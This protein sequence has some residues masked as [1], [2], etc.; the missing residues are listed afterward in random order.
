[1]FRWQTTLSEATPAPKHG[2][3]KHIQQTNCRVLA[4]LKQNLNDFFEDRQKAAVVDADPTSQQRDN[5]LD[6][7][8]LLVVIGQRVNRIDEHL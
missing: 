4:N 8:Q 2:A 5:R 7:R 6:L 3:H 1:M